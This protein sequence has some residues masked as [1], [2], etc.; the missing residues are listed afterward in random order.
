MA[1]RVESVEFSGVWLRP[2][3]EEWEVDDFLDR[4]VATLRGTA[5]DPVSASEVRS[6][7]FSSTRPG[8]AYDTL[9]VDTF[10]DEIEQF[11]SKI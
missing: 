11:L 9:D 10:L 6:I 3:Y 2:G 8:P 4:V 7:E 5:T 1:C